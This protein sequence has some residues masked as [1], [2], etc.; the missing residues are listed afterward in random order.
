ME[1]TPAK[2]E[3]YLASITAAQ[4]NAA[5]V[6]RELAARICSATVRGDTEALP[7][8][9]FALAL[10]ARQGAQHAVQAAVDALAQALRAYPSSAAVQIA[11]LT[12]LRALAV[13]GSDG[14]R[15][16]PGFVEASL[17]ALA[18]HGVTQGEAAEVL[19]V[20]C[21]HTLDALC[22]SAEQRAKFGTLR[23][24]EGVVAALKAHST[25]EHVQEF[26]CLLLENVCSNTP[27]NQRRADAAGAIGVIM[28]AVKE[29]HAHPAVAQQHFA[30]LGAICNARSGSIAKAAELGAV[31][32]AV[33]AMRA[34][35]AETML[36]EMAARALGVFAAAPTTPPPQAT[37][38][39][40]A[41]AIRAGAFD[42][43]VSAMQRHVGTPSLQGVCAHAIS[44]LCSASADSKAKAGAAGVIEAVIAAMRA[45]VADAEVQDRCCVAL[46]NLAGEPG[47][48]ARA[49][50]G[51]SLRD[52][53]AAMRAHARNASL[54]QHAGGALSNL[55]ADNPPFKSKAVDAGAL[56][57]LASALRT[58]VAVEA[59]LTSVCCALTHFGSD[60]ALS[61]TAAAAGLIPALVAALRAHPASADVHHRACMA[62]G[63]ICMHGVDDVGRTVQACNAGAIELLTVAVNT[64]AA[65]PDILEDV[66]FC[67]GHL[68]IVPAS[69]DRVGASG[70]VE[71]VAAVLRAFG[72]TDVKLFIL[73]CDIM[74]MLATTHALNQD[75]AGAA[76]AV[77]AIVSN[78]ASSSWT[79]D[80]TLTEQA[81]GSGFAA[82]QTLTASHAVNA[83]R[84]VC[85]GALALWAS[86]PPPRATFRMQ[87]TVALL[88]AA[89]RHDATPCARPGCARCA[90][91]RARGLMCALEGCGRRVRAAD[92]AKKLLR[93]AG[94]RVAGYCGAEHQQLDWRRHKA[95]CRAM[96]QQHAE[97]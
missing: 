3:A 32:A 68:F 85:T 80:A 76:G 54:Q 48:Q 40:R 88:P 83:A 37:C 51:G 89:Q 20:D 21:C 45:N 24:V 60:E 5:S 33:S 46:Q 43:I 31:E 29:H 63:F 50:R 17:A 41:R 4:P 53:V 74:H 84:A 36:Q 96:Q 64:F 11:G 79:N 81:H 34:H 86:S 13:Y 90:E 75:R 30:A 52:I 77:E 95:E 72:A 27:D 70:G 14:D 73:G 1:Y 15:H 44:N 8:C 87:L 59:V 82:L 66:L 92:A 28:A 23:G 47:A 18:A 6:F 49:C 69:R 2:V 22:V 55:V 57:V 61:A 42:A 19:T 35:T 38:A 67:L 78:L 94:C 58:H 93:C 65:R 25:H 10:T 12:A 71:G 26:A 97:E 16:A 56:A 9:C 62:L 91:L 39:I 7:L